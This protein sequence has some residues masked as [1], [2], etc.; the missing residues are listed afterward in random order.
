M[1]FKPDRQMIMKLYREHDI[2]EI[3]TVADRVEIYESI[4][5]PSEVHEYKEGLL[6]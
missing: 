1:F 3:L 4:L 6:A 5:T 2:H